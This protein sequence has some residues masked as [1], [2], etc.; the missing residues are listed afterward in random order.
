MSILSHFRQKYAISFVNWDIYK[1]VPWSVYQGWYALLTD[2]HV[3]TTLI[4]HMKS[5]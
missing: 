1:Y 5:F 4:Y 2:D 3:I